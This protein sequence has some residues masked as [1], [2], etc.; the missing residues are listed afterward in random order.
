MSGI[1]GPCNAPCELGR[2]HLNICHNYFPVE[3]CGARKPAPP[4][5]GERCAFLPHAGSPG[6]TWEPWTVDLATYV[7]RGIYE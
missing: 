7:D 4:Q 2:P 5:E 1:N 6:H 3:V